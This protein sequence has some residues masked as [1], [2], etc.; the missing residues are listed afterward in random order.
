M[1]ASTPKR[2]YLTK[3]DKEAII[4][5]YK[6]TGKS[7]EGF[8]VYYNNESNVYH[9]ERLRT[10]EVKSNASTTPTIQPTIPPTKKQNEIKAIFDGSN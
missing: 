10:S 8:K 2:N 5:E 6:A 3:R 1:T 4:N 9:I 7:R